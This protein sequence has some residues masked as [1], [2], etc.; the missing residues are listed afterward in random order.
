MRNYLKIGSAVVFLCLVLGV[1]LAVLAKQDQTTIDK[2]SCAALPHGEEARKCYADMLRP[3]SI[4]QLQNM[5]TKVETMIVDP[6]YGMHFAIECHEV[7][8]NLGKELDESMGPIN[9]SQTPV[10]SC[11]T[12]FQHGVAENRL[13]KLSDTELSAS[14]PS[15]CEGQ[16][17]SVCRH[18][19]GHVI[20]RRAL[21]ATSLPDF[22]YV[23]KACATSLQVAG[24]EAAL[25]EFRCLDGAYMEW[26]LWAMRTDDRSVPSPPQVACTDIRDQSLVASSACLAQV[27]TLMYGV[28]PDAK[29]TLA[30]CEETLKDVSVSAVR[31]CV[32]SVTNAIGSFTEDPVSAANNLC[33]DDLRLDC[34]IG[35]VRSASANLGDSTVEDLCGKILQEDVVLCVKESTGPY[36]FEY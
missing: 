22:S 11:A 14:A 19:I 1:G 33:K 6:D 27:G 16:D 5:F 21:I 28:Y 20:M 2:S 18:I 32:Y 4:D 3:K 34:A 9:I 17:L 29:T 24:R 8:H 31:L 15:W 7:L 23:S 30:A 25:D 35:F 26:T 13:A 10:Q 36:P 12:G